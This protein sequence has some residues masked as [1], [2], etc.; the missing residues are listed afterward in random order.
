MKQ[1]VTIEVEFEENYCVTNPIKEYSQQEVI[2]A[3]RY[4]IMD[5]LQARLQACK[6]RLFENRDHVVSVSEYTIQ[7]LTENN[8]LHHY[9]IPAARAMEETIANFKNGDYSLNTMNLVQ[10][11]KALYWASDSVRK[12]RIDG[13]SFDDLYSYLLLSMGDENLPVFHP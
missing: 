3:W 9:S 1:K 2:K 6:T 7:Y 10:I 12:Q 11:L 4:V 5:V 8:I 13:V